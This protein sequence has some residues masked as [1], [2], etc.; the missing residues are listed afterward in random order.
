MA[1]NPLESLNMKEEDFH[2]GSHSTRPFRSFEG[3]ATFQLRRDCEVSERV[4][5]WEA[6]KDSEEG[7]AGCGTAACRLLRPAARSFAL[8]P[9]IYT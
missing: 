2:R 3:T 7:M 9:L 5:E 4:S 8:L 1:K 6:G